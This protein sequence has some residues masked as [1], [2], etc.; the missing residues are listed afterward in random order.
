MASVDPEI[1]VTP[2]GLTSPDGA[3]QTMTTV[4]VVVMVTPF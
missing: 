4:E 3:S 1:T 2:V